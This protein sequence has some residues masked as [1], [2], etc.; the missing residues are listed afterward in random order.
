M[1]SIKTIRS[2]SNPVA[3]LS[4]QPGDGQRGY[5][6]S[7]GEGENLVHFRDG[8]RISIKASSAAGSDRMA[9]ATQQV[10][11]GSG[12]PPH[13]HIDMDEVFYVLEGSGVFCLN[14]VRH[15]FD[16]G[17][18]IFIPRNTWHAFENADE[19]LLLLWVV[20]PA[21]LD[22][23]FRATCSRDGEPAKDLT[24]EEIH[25]LALQ[26]GTEFQ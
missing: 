24:S 7:G 20:S 22:G 8:G 19:E 2:S 18:T 12:I 15:L 21:L 9:L 11:K 3:S 1:A 25:V 14:D 10:M 16:K 5:V 23:F 26:Y 4:E 13:R 17:A 6:L